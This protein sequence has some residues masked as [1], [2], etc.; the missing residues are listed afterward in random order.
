VVDRVD[1]SWKS[2]PYGWPLA[3][4]SFHVLTRDLR[5]A[6]TGVPGELYI[7]GIGVAK[8]YYNDPERTAAS[9]ITHP[10]TGERLYRTGDM[11]RYHD[12]GYLEFLGRNDDQV[13][14]RGFRIELGEIDAVLDRC[15]GVRSAATIVRQGNSQDR[16]LVTLYVPE[17]DS[18]SEA[19]IR[20]HLA[21]TLPDYMVPAQFI[22]LEQIPVT[23]NGKVNRKA[24]AD[25]AAALPPVVREKR[26]PRTAD[27]QR[28]AGIWQTLLNIDEPGI[29][30]NF[31]EQ[32]GTSLLAVR[33]LNAIAAEFG[34]SLPL[35]S[36][37]RHGTIAAQ[38]ALLAQDAAASSGRSPLVALRDGVDSTLVVVHPVGGN[39]LCYRELTGLVPDGMAVLALQS[40]GDGSAREV[41][42]LAASY[43]EALS[44]HLSTVRPLYLL[45]WSM[46]GVI[47]QEMARQLEAAGI[48]PVGL[49]LIDSWQSADS[50]TASQLEGYAL[51]HNF[52][53]DLLGSTPMPDAFAAIE[54]LDVSQQPEAALAVLRDNGVSG[55]QMSAK[56]FVVL[57]NEYQA[58]Y[59]ALVR[60]ASQSVS[61]PTRLFRAT[62]SQ[63]FPLLAGFAA[64]DG[65][66]FEQVAMDEDHFSIFQGAPLRTILA[67]SLQTQE[68][69]REAVL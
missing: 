1:P 56:E 30:D 57:L 47:A 13:K 34:K 29:D 42:E 22:E 63:R 35:A 38:A 45:G 50:H 46:G 31:F 19:D 24:L 2:I 58:N 17:N 40:P 36:L 4:Q 43:I 53:R 23:A 37:L 3:N 25:I 52:V 69:A 48:A 41:S 10:Q 55:G 60:H 44:G 65:G 67:L 62:R 64:P 16:Q 61:T 15:P 14:I 7:G 18:V 26:A 66:H 11:G 33:L 12:S 49:T 32:G 5:H 68:D 8:G 59:N 51:L 20:E 9:F 39:V 6:P 21:R 28:L 54:A 27:E